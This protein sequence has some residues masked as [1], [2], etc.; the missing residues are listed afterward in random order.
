MITHDAPY[1]QNLIDSFSIKD[2]A[3]H[4]AISVDM[5]DTGIDVPEVVNLVFFKMVRSKSKFWQMIGRGTRLCPDLYGPGDDKQ[6]FLVFDFCGNLEYFSQDLP[7]SEGSTQKSLS[8]RIFETRLGLVAALDAVGHHPDLRR[9]AATEL[10]EFVAGMNLGNVLVRP[11]RRAVERFADWSSWA[12]LTTES[13]TDALGL[14]GLPS[15]AKDDDEDAKRFD[16]LILRRQLAQLQG[17]AVIAEQIRD[18]VQR[19]AESL[20]GK[21]T[22][23]SVSAQSELLDAVAGDEWWMDVTC[24]MLELAR[25]RLRGLV[26]FV[27]KTRRNPVYTDFEDVLGEAMEVHLPGIT[28][29]TNF[30]RFRAKA[31]AYLK[32]H[33]DHVALQRLRRNRQL[34]ADDLVSLEEMLVEAGGQRV[35]I[36]WATEKTGGLGLFIRGLVGLDRSAAVDAFGQFLDDTNFSVHQVRFINLI[37]DELTANG[38]MEPGRLYESPYTDHAP[39]GPDYIFPNSD[40]DVIVEILNG[41]KDHAVPGGAA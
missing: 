13:A 37:V 30:E 17:D 11:H 40:I 6:D 12:A 27:E 10:Y 15:A 33:E 28:P 14:A 19:I 31:M 29:G 9:E 25:I 36:A 26:R 5:L 23:P 34:T 24:P 35:D 2:K 18:T 22:I 32:Q 41:V 16:L 7:S 38:V 1:A 20:L 39:T 21:L 3:P 4:I 8:Q